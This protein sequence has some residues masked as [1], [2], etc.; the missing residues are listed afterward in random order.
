MRE[1]VAEIKSRLTTN[2]IFINTIKTFI[3]IYMFY[4]ETFQIILN[5]S[6]VKNF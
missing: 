5:S 2:N 6:S 4:F 3:K 1:M